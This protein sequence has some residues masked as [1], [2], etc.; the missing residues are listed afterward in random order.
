MKIMAHIPPFFLD[1]VVAI[2]VK[3]EKDELVWVGTGFIIGR[4]SEPGSKLYYTY[5]VTN[6]HIFEK[7]KTVF[8]RFNPQSNEKAKDYSLILI[9]DKNNILWTGHP[10]EDIDVA[11]HGI[12]FELLKS[13]GMKCAFF[14]PDNHVLTK[15]QM[16]DSGICE[17]DFIYVLGFPMNLV[18]ERKYVI[19]RSGVIAQI[20]NYLDGFSKDF[21]VDSFIFPGNSGGPVINKT[22]IS[23]IQDT[24]LLSKACLIGMIQSYI[25]YRDIAV[26]LQTK[27]VRTISVENSGLAS[28]IPT[29]FIFET[30]EIAV[31]KIIKQK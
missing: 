16:I 2:G 27:E 29:D 25:P 28:V 14:E 31:K 7:Q 4:E 17:G 1:T 18:G 24:K 10:A 20:K 5:L 22:E 26:S 30:V 3:N 13:E 6:K 11:V 23:G 21:L 19:T 8:L 15:Q 12:N 9:D